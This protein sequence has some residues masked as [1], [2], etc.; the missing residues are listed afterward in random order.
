MREKRGKKRENCQVWQKT[1]QRA[2]RSLYTK[3]VAEFRKKIVM[4]CFV[5]QI[6]KERNER[7]HGQQPRSVM[8]VF[9]RVMK[10]I[11]DRVQGWRRIK[12]SKANL[13]ISVEWGFGN[14]IFHA[15]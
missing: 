8:L 1:A 4:S 7:M 12:R 9:D 14:S 3:I 13:D 10:S 5:Y 6:W 2:T 11:S 15:R